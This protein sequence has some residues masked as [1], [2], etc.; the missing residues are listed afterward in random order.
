MG[1]SSAVDASLTAEQVAKFHRDGYL[2]LP[3]FFT[4]EAPA[5]LEHAK[6]LIKAFDPADHPL[7]AFKTGDKG[8]EAKEEEKHIGDRYFLSSGDKISYFLEEGAL[9]PEGK[10]LREPER[11]VNKCG[12]ALHALDPVFAKFSFSEKVKQVARSLDVHKDPKVLQSMIV[13]TDWAPTDLFHWTQSLLTHELVHRSASNHRSAAL[14]LR[15]T[16]R[17]SSTPTLR[18]R[19]ASGSRSRTA[20]RRM[21]RCRSCRLPPVASRCAAASHRSA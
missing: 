19:W 8:E 1:A 3:R 18:Q 7:T 6:Q 10:L 4:D 17:H 20:Q 16:T 5:L 11:S 14:S 21:A 9:S 12:H 13:S 2:V 15:T